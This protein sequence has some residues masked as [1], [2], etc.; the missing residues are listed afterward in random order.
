MLIEDIAFN[1]RVTSMQDQ[2]TKECIEIDQ[3]F[4]QILSENGY[5]VCFNCGGKE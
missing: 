4:K 3:H 5:D 2:L 1:E